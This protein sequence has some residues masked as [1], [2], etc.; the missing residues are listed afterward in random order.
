MFFQKLSAGTSDTAKESE[1][2]NAVADER[3]VTLQLRIP[4]FCLSFEQISFRFL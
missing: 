2:I 3:K 4:F 1:F